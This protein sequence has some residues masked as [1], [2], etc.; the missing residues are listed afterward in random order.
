MRIGKSLILLAVFLLLACTSS[1]EKKNLSVDNL[2]NF[3]SYISQVTQGIISTR[4]D[5]RVVLTQPVNSWESGDELDDALLTSKPRV[6]GKVIALDS[7]TISFSPEKGLD[8]DTEYLFTLNLGEIVDDIP[9][10]RRLLTFGLKTIKQQFNVYAGPL[11]SR[12]KNLQYLEAQLRSADLMSIATAKELVKVERNGNEIP[13]NFEE[14]IEESRQFVFRIDSIQR[15]EEDSELLISWTGK[16]MGIESEGKNTLKIP[17]KNNFS[18]LDVRVEQSPQQHLLINFSDPLKKGQNFKGL[19]VLE[20]DDNPKYSVDGNTLKLYPSKEIKGTATLELFEGIENQE[21]YKTKLSIQ[22][23]VS[24][25][26]L[27]PQLKLLSNATILPSSNNLKINFETVNLL[28]VDVKVLK[29][30]QSN[31]LQFLQGNNLSGAY[32]LRTVARPVARKKINLQSSISDVDGKW[33]AHALD[34][35]KLISPEVG[36]IYRVEFDFKPSYSAY[37]CSTDNFETLESSEENFDE[38]QEDSSWDGVENYYNNYYYNYDW[39][40]RENPCHTSYYYDKKVGLNVLAT[41]I[42]ITV[43]KGVNKSYFVAVNDLLNTN[44]IAG[45]KVSFYNYQQQLIGSVTTDADGTSIFDSEK[46]AYFAKVESAGQLNYVKLN[47]GNVLSVSKFN[48]A[49][50]ELQKGLKGFLFAERGVWRP[51][52]NI[53]LSFMLNDKANEL[54]EDHPVTLT[55]FDPYNKKMF[56]EVKTSG[57]NGFYHFQI[58][59]SE[60]APTGNWLAKVSIGGASF[61]KSLRI[62]TIKP[63]RLKI[64]TDFGGEILSSERPIQ[65]SMEVKWLHGAIAK[66]LKADITAKF[67]RQATSFTSFPAYTFDDP[68][69]NFLTEEQTV[70]DGRIDGQGEASFQLKP[71]LSSTAPGMLRASFITKVYESG[72]DFSTDVFSKTYSPFNTYVGLNTPKGDKTRGMLLTDTKHLFEVVTLNEEGNP[73][74]VKDLRVTVH[75]VNWR[76]WW[77]TS[78]DNLSNFSSSN[79]REKVFDKRINTG[80]DGKGSFEFELKY[81][82]WGRYLVRVEDEEGGHASGKTIYIDWPGWA[83]KSRKN[84]PSAATMLVFS[85]DKEKYN[86]G[87]RATVTFPSSG[88]GRALVTVENGSEVLESLWIE[89][90]NGETK[91]DLDIKELYTPNVYIHI[92]L[93]QPHANTIN[94]SPIRLYGVLPLLAENPNTRLQPELNLPEVLRPEETISLK[95]SERN[96]RGMTYSIAMVDEGLLDL[97]RFKTPDPWAGF[98]ARQALGVKTWDVYD[99]VIGAFGGRIDQVFAIGG[100]GDLAGAKN[101]KANRFEPMFTEL[102]LSSTRCRL[103]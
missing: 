75:K 84:D 72:G 7:R 100:D 39:N 13:I 90:Q 16:K 65:G 76:W 4:D 20:G 58:A 95:V 55:L 68:T 38:A 37:T 40:E 26:Q 64:K 80:T 18:V 73:K 23:K 43:K 103:T 77:D 45:A 14:G 54:P 3:T 70:F 9:K 44:P 93:L 56:R 60:N 49:G 32:N 19:I 35:S 85:A 47:D 101:K 57:L 63:N 96:G 59:T 41:D 51:G 62:E 36:A 33:K 12:T 15:L 22:Q 78:A 30:Y 5:I 71:Q 94:D 99:D 6:K 17:G 61:S 27:K 79:Y 46:L 67:A 24:F 102:T 83:G 82:E 91:F 29:I 52:D 98:Y 10:D 97:T 74:Q 87:E 2:D 88:G 50:V 21:G 28:A 42:G 48:V 69:R 81:P 8:Q 11:Q 66:N 53:F 1:E 31:I 25:E 89:T 34:L 92:S 86:V